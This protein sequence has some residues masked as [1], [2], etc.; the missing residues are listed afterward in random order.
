MG[1]DNRFSSAYIFVVAPLANRVGTVPRGTPHKIIRPIQRLIYFGP[2]SKTLIKILRLLCIMNLLGCCEIFPPDTKRISERE[3]KR[4]L[5]S[6]TKT[7]KSFIMW[8]RNSLDCNYVA[9]FA[10]NL[11]INTGVSRDT[12]SNPYCRPSCLGCYIWRIGWRY[13][14]VILMGIMC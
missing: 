2:F 1:G 13:C 12:L 7:E 14:W 6:E 11:K 9:T 10:C 4:A 3:R 8:V 5:Y